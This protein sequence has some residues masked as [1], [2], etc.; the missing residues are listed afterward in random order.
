MDLAPLDALKEACKAKDMRAQGRLHAAPCLPD[1]L[2]ATKGNAV[3]LPLEPVPPLT[4]CGWPRTFERASRR[5]IVSW[6]QIVRG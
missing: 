5:A 2:K 1:E 6:G 3:P 4:R